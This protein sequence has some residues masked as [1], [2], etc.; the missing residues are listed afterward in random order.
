MNGN[1]G[2][3]YETLAKSAYGENIR[4]FDCRDLPLIYTWTP[5]DDVAYSASYFSD[6]L[7]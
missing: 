7:A 2:I 4:I 3:K 5:T 1:L 6:D